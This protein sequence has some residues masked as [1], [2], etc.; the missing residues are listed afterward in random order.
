VKGVAAD[1][2]TIFVDI[3][4]K[5]NKFCV[6]LNMKMFFPPQLAIVVLS[7]DYFVP[8]FHHN[9]MSSFISVTRDE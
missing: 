4:V 7:Q 2:I 1:A 6:Y 8:I 3:T 9:F 5:I